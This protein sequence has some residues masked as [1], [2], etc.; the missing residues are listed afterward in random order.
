MNRIF[1]RIHD[2][3]HSFGWLLIPTPLKAL[4]DGNKN[5]RWIMLTDHWKLKLTDK[6]GFHN[7]R[8]YGG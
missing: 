1:D 4:M 5:L 7:C 3:L 8:I 2:P 6:Y